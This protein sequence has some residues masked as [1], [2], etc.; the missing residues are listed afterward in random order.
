MG[1]FDFLISSNFMYAFRDTSTYILIFKLWLQ[2]LSFQDI[3]SINHWKPF[4]K[5]KKLADSTFHAKKMAEKCVPPAMV[6]ICFLCA[7]L[8]EI[9]K[10]WANES[11]QLII[12]ID[13]LIWR[14]P[15]ICSSCNNLHNCIFSDVKWVVVN[16]NLWCKHL[17]FMLFFLGVKTLFFCGSLCPEYFAGI[18]K[19]TY[20]L[21]RGI[22]QSFVSVHQDFIEL[23]V[24]SKGIKNV[25][26][27]GN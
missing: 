13:K 15:D 24:F 17:E 25:K 19:M 21:F 1:W 10:S 16:H 5:G 12:R 26:D 23:I 6:I 2:I 9:L 4:K 14:V 18:N 20:I 22:C 7:T 3:C 8:C 27:F 11:C